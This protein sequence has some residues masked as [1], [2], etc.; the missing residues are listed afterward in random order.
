MV[1]AWMDPE[2]N[3]LF[4]PAACCIHQPVLLA[5]IAQIDQHISMLCNLL[6]PSPSVLRKNQTPEAL[7]ALLTFPS[8]LDAPPARVAVVHLSVWLARAKPFL[9]PGVA[10]PTTLL[11]KGVLASYTC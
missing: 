4:A 7:A 8:S 10:R 6:Q 3:L 2:Y 11:S 5:N 9:E 1:E